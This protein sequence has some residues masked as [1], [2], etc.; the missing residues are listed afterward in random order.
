MKTSV[1]RLVFFYANLFF[2]AEH[3]ELFF[4]SC[5]AV[6]HIHL[7]NCGILASIKAI[8]E[9]FLFQKINF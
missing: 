4:T 1:E 5:P 7:Q 6:H 2:G 8:L 9:I 3:F